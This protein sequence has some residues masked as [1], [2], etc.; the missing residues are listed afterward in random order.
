M[1]AETSLHAAVRSAFAG[2]SQAVRLL[3][4]VFP[5]SAPTGC[6]APG[7]RPRG[8]RGGCLRPARYPVAG[9]SGDDDS[10]ALKDIQGLPV[11][12]SIG[13]D[14]GGTDG[15]AASSRVSRDLSDG[16]AT[17]FE[18]HFEDALGTRPPQDLAGLSRTLRRAD[19]RADPRRASQANRILAAAF[20]FAFDGLQRSYPARAFT[21][22]AG[23]SD[24]ACDLA[25]GRGGHRLAFSLQAWRTATPFTRSSSP[26]RRAS[27]SPTPSAPS[28]SSAPMPPRPVTP[29]HLEARRTLGAWCCRAGQLRLQDSPPE[30]CLRSSALDQGEAGDARPTASSTTP[31]TRPA[32]APGLP[33]SH[34]SGAAASS[35]TSLPPRAG[36]GERG[37]PLRPR[38]Q[39]C[40]GRAR[41]VDRHPPAQRSS[42]SPASSSPRQW[43]PPRPRPRAPPGPG[44]A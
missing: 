15:C 22:Q 3:K 42:T 4:V 6:T 17:V 39:F 41:R 28:A 21:M 29:S 10:L 40:A 33:T 13:D 35:P 8:G 34:S 27:T 24:A 19:H 1:I 16:A 43:H 20:R 23:E 30:R 31:T 25:A 18:L 7:R 26:M 36:R 44:L 11:G 5:P 2:T 38:A 37:A 12:L 9:A 14:E 32:P